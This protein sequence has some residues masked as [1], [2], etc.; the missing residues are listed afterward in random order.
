MDYWAAARKF[1]EDKICT[2][3]VEESQRHIWLDRQQGKCFGSEMGT[4]S[5]YLVGGG[6]ARKS[7][8]RHKTISEWLFG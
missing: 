8:P 1:D 5:L 6:I 4:P 7:F 2:G 3:P